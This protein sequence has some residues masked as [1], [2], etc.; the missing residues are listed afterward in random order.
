MF[1][2]STYSEDDF[3]ELV[4]GGVNRLMNI[5]LSNIVSSSKSCE[6]FRIAGGSVD[7]Y[8]GVGAFSTVVIDAFGV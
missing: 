7:E 5:F 2:G 1:D 8:G 4:D 6:V 3:A